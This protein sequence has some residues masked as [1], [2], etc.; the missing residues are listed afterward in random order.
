[1]M[2]N[3]ILPLLFFPNI[4]YSSGLQYFF[5]YLHMAA[6]EYFQYDLIFDISD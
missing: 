6:F 2:E 1:M 4:Q 5:I 3:M